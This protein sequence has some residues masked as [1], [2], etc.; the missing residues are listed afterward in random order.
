MNHVWGREISSYINPLYVNLW[1]YLLIFLA[2]TQWRSSVRPDEWDVCGCHGNGWWAETEITAVNHDKSLIFALTHIIHTS[3]A[4]VLQM[5]RL[6]LLKISVPQEQLLKTATQKSHMTD[7][8]FTRMQAF[9]RT[10]GSLSALEETDACFMICN[11]SAIL[12]RNEIK[13]N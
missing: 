3:P 4:R 1:S 9:R 13:M 6:Y 12:Q 11:S 7:F 10:P 5:L 8:P 2:H